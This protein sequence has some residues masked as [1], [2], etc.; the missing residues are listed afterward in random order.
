[1]GK[2]EQSM[3][4]DLTTITMIVHCIQ[5]IHAWIMEKDN[6]EGREEGKGNNHS[7][8]TLEPTVVRCTHTV[9]TANSVTVIPFYSSLLL[10]RPSRCHSRCH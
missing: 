8:L 10:N 3:V 6:E 9:H 5:T 7:Y 4:P 2:G 1:M